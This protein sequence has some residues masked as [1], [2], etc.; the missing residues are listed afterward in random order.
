[1]PTNDPARDSLQPPSNRVSDFEEYRFSELEVDELFWETNSKNE[2]TPWR[3]IS[4]TQGYNIKAG[5]TSNIKP[6][7]VVYQRI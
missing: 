7:T 2:S 1:M 4:N 6:G 3:K 5:T